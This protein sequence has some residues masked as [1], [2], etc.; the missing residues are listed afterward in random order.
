MKSLIVLVVGLLAVGCEKKLTPEQKLRDS[1]LGEYEFKDLLGKTNKWVFLENGVIERYKISKKLGEE[2]WSVVEGE[3]HI[4]Y[5]WGE[6][7]ILRINTDK[8]ITLIASIVDEKRTD[9]PKDKQE[10][11]KKI[12]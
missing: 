8:S 5:D 6:I 4:V 3:I 2:K 11:Y 10:T 1:V 9:W 12:K 7:L